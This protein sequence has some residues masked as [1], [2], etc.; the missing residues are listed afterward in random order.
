PALST[1]DGH[2][3]N[4]FESPQYAFS[5]RGW[6][7][8]AMELEDNRRMPHGPYILDSNIDYSAWSTIRAR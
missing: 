8:A 2:R 7:D 4:P 3:V 1:L 5:E 6:A